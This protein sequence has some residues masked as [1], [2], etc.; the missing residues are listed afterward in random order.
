MGLRLPQDQQHECKNQLDIADASQ[1]APRHAPLTR[2]Q[3]FSLNTGARTLAHSLANTPSSKQRDTRAGSPADTIFSFEDEDSSTPGEHSSRIFSSIPPSFDSP[4]IGSPYSIV[5]E[6]PSDIPQTLTPPPTV[7][8]P[9]SESESTDA[10]ERAHQP[11]VRT[12]DWLGT[13]R[14]PS[15]SSASSTSTGYPAPPPLPLPSTPS[16]QTGANSRALPPHLQPPVHLAPPALPAP[17]APPAPPALSTAPAAQPTS[18][19]MP[20]ATN[21][22]SDDAVEKA[23][24]RLDAAK[25]FFDGSE[26]DATEEEWR[27]RFENATDAYGLSEDQKLSMWR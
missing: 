23:R 7:G 5:D 3:P 2:T 27:E 16:A 26:V 1:L 13:P 21:A 14:T 8:R 24:T 9:R 6:I 22:A 20:P 15:T 10:T 11:P 17:S 12:K 25:L 19:P 18:S 4:P